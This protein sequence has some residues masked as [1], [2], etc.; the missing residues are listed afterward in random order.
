MDDNKV[1]IIIPV[2][3]EEK[4]I[5]LLLDAL[6]R[7]S[8]PFDEIVITDGG[9]SDGTV[10]IISSYSLKDNR[11]K[12]ISVNKANPG[13]GRNI[14]IRN[15][16]GSILAFMDSGIVPETDWLGKIVDPMIKNDDIECVFGHV[17]FDTKS[18]IK[19]ISD[20]QKI[21]V[22]LTKPGEDQHGFY[23]PGSAIKRRVWESMQGF[24]DNSETGEDLVLIDMVKKG[25]YKFIYVKD[26]ICHYFDYPSTPGSIF[27]KWVFHTKGTTTVFTSVKYFYIKLILF[28]I[29]SLLFM[30]LIV[31]SLFMSLRLTVLL[32]GLFISAMAL[33]L[34]SRL[35]THKQ[36]SNDLL[37]HPGNWI[38]LILLFMLL[39]IARITGI[40]RGLT[41]KMCKKIKASAS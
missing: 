16:T 24:P 40:Y 8:Y 3:N 18:R 29:L 36:L 4:N 37:K 1:S 6:F 20:L 5:G 21:L 11:I 9:S 28:F 23:L 39:D 19:P 33:R 35:Q 12:L 14:A 13:Q 2:K 38:E 31:V 17:V 7:Q 10:Q 22:L 41:Q 34:I 30:V 26:A 15:S 25:G 27:K 32:V